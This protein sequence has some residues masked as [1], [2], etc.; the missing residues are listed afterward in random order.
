MYGM[1]FIFATLLQI[2]FQTCIFKDR[3]TKNPDTQLK[4]DKLE[5][6]KLHGIDKTGITVSTLCLIECTLRPVILTALAIS[7]V[8]GIIHDLLALLVIP[9][10]GYAVYKAW[11][12]HR[13]PLVI[14]LLSVGTLLIVFSSLFLG[15]SHEHDHAGFELNLHLLL[16]IAG[17]LSLI[18]AHVLNTRYCNS[19]TVRA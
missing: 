6:N 11:K 3:K 19:C 18:T 17:G 4:F 10:S 2:L 15:H 8:G 14:S 7:N 1:K 5:H 13:D 16:V 9:V 12:S